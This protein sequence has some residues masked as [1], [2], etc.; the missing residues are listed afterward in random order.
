MILIIF[1]VVI[2]L[3]FVVDVSYG[4]NICTL[5]FKTKF[6]MLIDVN[7]KNPPY[8][9]ELGGL[10]CL[11]FKKKYDY[12]RTMQIYAFFISKPNFKC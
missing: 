1:I 8:S 11:I 10:S 3:I 5:Y 7:K 6:H 12:L 9:H 4:A 2:Y